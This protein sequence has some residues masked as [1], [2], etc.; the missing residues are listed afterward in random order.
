MFTI[1]QMGM[2][3]LGWAQAA[4][5]HGGYFSSGHQPGKPGAG[6][7]SQTRNKEAA[8]FQEDPSGLCEGLGPVT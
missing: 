6:G 5:A 7:Q 2:L 4:E 3:R 8:R 1:V